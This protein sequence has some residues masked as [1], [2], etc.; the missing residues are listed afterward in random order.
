MD[1]VHGLKNLKSYCL[2]L[3]KKILRIGISLRFSE[4]NM[5]QTSVK[6]G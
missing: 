1:E 4:F 3:L 5:F 2:F 6:L